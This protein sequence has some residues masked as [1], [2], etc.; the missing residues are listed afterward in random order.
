MPTPNNHIDQKELLVELKAGNQTAF[1]RFF[2]TNYTPLAKFAWK[3][4]RQNEVAEELVHDA[5]LQLWQKRESLQ[6]TSSLEGYLY[7]TVKNKCLNYLKSKYVKW[8][9]ASDLSEY[10]HP[11]TKNTEET[12]TAD[13][14]QTLLSEAID[15]LPPK[16]KAIFQLRNQ[17]DMT[18]EEIGKKL[19][20]SKKTVGAQ[21]CIALQ[22]L[23]TYLAEHWE[24]VCLVLMI[25]F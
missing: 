11:L 5:F 24:L 10:S 7:T 2:K 19:N 1:E 20:L 25:G 8:E 9:E 13:E 21:M 3:Y 14:L 23:K 17:T 22:K 6:I 15:A 18:Y 4:V 16:C 12:L